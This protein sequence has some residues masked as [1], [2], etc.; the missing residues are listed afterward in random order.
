MAA[1]ANPAGT[2]RGRKKH[3]RRA[4]QTAVTAL[5][6]GRNGEHL[7]SLVKAARGTDAMRHKRRIALRTFAQ[8]RE[9]EHAVISAALTLPAG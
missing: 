2:G 9:L 3:P 5:R 1:L 4:S 8:L 7:A 6:A